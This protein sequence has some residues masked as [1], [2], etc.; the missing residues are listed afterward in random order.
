MP[1]A[2]KVAWQFWLYLRNNNSIK[3]IFQEV[4]ILTLSTTLLQI[5]CKVKLYSKVIFKS[6]TGS[7]DTDQID[8]QAGMG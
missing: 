2:A 1:V 3:K 5:F 4:F 8:L 7:D 6:L